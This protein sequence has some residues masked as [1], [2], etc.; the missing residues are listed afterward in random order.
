MPLSRFAKFSWF[1]LAYNVAVLG[2]GGFVRASDSV[3]GCGR[4]WPMCNGEMLPHAPR[5]ATMIELAHRLTSGIS[6][7]LVVALAV[8]A[9]RTFPKGH[10]ARRSSLWSCAFIFG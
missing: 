6:V 7:A 3:A 10:A 9:F 4:H 8:A 2:W 1:V 5:V